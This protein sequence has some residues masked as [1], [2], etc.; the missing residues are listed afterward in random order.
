MPP[1]RRSHTVLLGRGPQVIFDAHD[2]RR[3]AVC[4][5]RADEDDPTWIDGLSDH[6]L[7]Y[8]PYR[9]AVE[10]RYARH[11]ILARFAADNTSS[12][13]RNVWR[14]SVYEEKLRDAMRRLAPLQGV[15]DRTTYMNPKAARAFRFL[16]DEF[17]RFNENNILWDPAFMGAPKWTVLDPLSLK[18]PPE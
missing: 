17:P 14:R 16:L 2:G 15:D 9:N 5:S 8:F 4:V 10:K 18:R 11:E 3:H 12:L 13:G 1:H 6:D 7:F